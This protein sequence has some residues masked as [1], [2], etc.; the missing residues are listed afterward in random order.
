MSWQPSPSPRLDCLHCIPSH[1]RAAPLT[2]L[3]STSFV[4]GKL[5]SGPT[6]THYE[7]STRSD[8]CT[9]L[10]MQ[11]M[12]VFKVTM[13][14]QENYHTWNKKS[15]EDQVPLLERELFAIHIHNLVLLLLYTKPQSPLL[16]SGDAQ[17]LCRTT[18]AQTMLAASGT[19]NKLNNQYWNHCV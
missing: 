3:S 13:S 7:R 4:K 10:W 9:L 11:P 1:R 6:Y 2:A 8:T 5:G 17:R 14:H 16:Q 15:R 19:E 12:A 18:T